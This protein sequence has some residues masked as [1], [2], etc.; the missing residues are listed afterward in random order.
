MPVG[1]VCDGDAE[2]EVLTE[3][4]RRF[5]G[6][7][8]EFGRVVYADMQPKAP[9]GQIVRAASLKLPILRARGSDAIVVVLD[10]EDGVECPGVRAAEI[11]AAFRAAGHLD[12][13]VVIKDRKLENW[14]IA[15]AEAV[16]T[17]VGF[18]IPEGVIRRIERAGADSITDAER[19]LRGCARRDYSKRRDAVRMAQ[20]ATAHSLESRSRSFRRLLR[21]SGDA[22]FAHQSRLRLA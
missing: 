19:E 17:L 14:L 12:V 6:H 20:V 15:S 5:N 10:R 18:E 22:R 9:V 21:V 8:V 11:S 4:L 13:R 7:G 1:I 16:S 3:L 2:V